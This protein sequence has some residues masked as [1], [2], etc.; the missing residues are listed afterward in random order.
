MKSVS[1]SLLVAACV[2]IAC[3]GEDAK[4]VA[5]GKGIG[6]VRVGETPQELF[7]Y[8]K[9]YLAEQYGVP[10]NVLPDGTAP[11]ATPEALAEKLQAG[12]GDICL[13]A[14]STFPEGAKDEIRVSLDRRVGVVNVTALDP[15][16]KVPDQETDWFTWR[17]E[18]ES[19]RVAAHLVG[20]PVCPFAKCALFAHANNLQLDA[21]ARNLCPPCLHKAR[22]AL[23]ARGAVFPK[24]E[25][26]KGPPPQ[27]PD[28]GE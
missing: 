17:I 14:L 4:P 20:V 9:G 15:K 24:K 12:E 21:K 2:V 16:G 13:V 6:L 19:M 1:L 7:D 25:Q 11:A 10:V 27:M 23:E 18:K 5:V 22:A 26:P 28:K 3:L 8:I